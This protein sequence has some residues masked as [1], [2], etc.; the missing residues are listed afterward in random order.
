M[1]GQPIAEADT[2]TLCSPFTEDKKATF[3][4]FNIML[5]PKYHKA[6]CS[7]AES[8]LRNIKKKKA[9]ELL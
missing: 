3:I 9:S 6:N 7:H 4:E 5:L 2:A 8:I 1:T